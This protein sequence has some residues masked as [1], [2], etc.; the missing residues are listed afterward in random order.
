MH[1]K[2][3]IKVMLQDFNE[4]SKKVWNLLGCLLYGHK[5]VKGMFWIGISRGD[6]C[7]R[8]GQT[9]WHDDP[10]GS[11]EQNEKIKKLMNKE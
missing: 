8:C 11:N 1:R 7:M 9:E 5:T 3:G 10:E 6:K 2:D 4:F